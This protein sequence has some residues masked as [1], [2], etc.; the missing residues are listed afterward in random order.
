M[1][2][3]NQLQYRS[4]IDGLR[5]V[6]VLSVI[7]FH[8]FG[9]QAGF[10][11]VDIFFVISGYLISSII[12]TQLQEERFSL[13]AFYQH[14]IRRIFPA[15]LTVLFF[16][17][18]LGWFVLLAIEFEL[19][20]KHIA[21]GLTFISN[22]VLLS[23]SGYFDPD[24][25]TKILLHLWSLGIEEQFY[26]VWPL[27]L[28]FWW[29]WR[30]HYLSLLIPILVVS[31]VSNVTVISTHPSAAF[32]LPI[33]RF[34]E[35]LIGALLAY[36]I[37][38][39]GKSFVVLRSANLTVLLGLIAL[40]IC[41]IFLNDRSQ[42]PGWWALLPTLGS[43]L[44]I[45][46]GQA[47]WFNKYVLGSRVMVWIGLISYPL[48]LWHWPLLTFARILEGGRQSP[49][50]TR[51][52]MF[53]LT[54]ILAWFTYQF[55]EK[56]IR[57]NKAAFLGPGKLIAIALGFLICSG[58]VFLEKGLPL[59]AANQ[60]TVLYQ[61]DTGHEDF[62]D[63]LGKQSNIQDIK[64]CQIAVIGDSHAV[65]L[66][67]GLAEALPHQQFCYFNSE[68]TLPFISSA[69]SSSN[70]NKIITHSKIRTV[71]LSAYWNLR[72]P[73]IP[74]GSNFAKEIIETTEKLS[75]A[76]KKVFVVSGIPNFD[77]YPTKCT[78]DWPW[79][80][81][82]QCID[83]D[84]VQKQYLQYQPEFEIAKEHS[85]VNILDLYSY[86]CSENSCSMAKDGQLLF[87]DE[88]H[89]NINGSRFIAIPIASQ[90]N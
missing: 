17:F 21:A 49:A 33:T 48:Y 18:V 40:V 39:E 68:Q 29:R 66:I 80:R 52:A 77:F 56:P 67:A 4:D 15:L 85:K 59:R 79:I 24:S 62:M 37:A 70:L 61:G 8:F 71:I 22:L 7:G 6:A 11:G 42:F 47:A 12:F 34:W 57:F 26:I 10:I 36:R 81:Q 50:Q 14:R 32:Y 86:F 19:L 69:Y 41:N 35:L 78:F 58:Y 28:I 83:K 53:V 43:I 73:L 54:F 1:N 2:Q 87:R 5:A 74:S 84:F 30:L 9:I 13:M 63:Y 76:G 72:K 88:N 16:C 38:V 23:E 46:A 25:H 82:Q 64:E 90:L 3:Q 31:F 75:A 60:L 45:A 44:I 20:N 89:L 27:L 65:T 55:I 51:I